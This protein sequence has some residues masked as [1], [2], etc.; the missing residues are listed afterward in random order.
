MLNLHFI[1]TSSLK[2]SHIYYNM[3]MR[4]SSAIMISWKYMFRWI[5]STSWVDCKIGKEMRPSGYAESPLA[6]VTISHFEHFELS[7]FQSRLQCLHAH[8]C[9]NFSQS[10][11]LSGYTCIFMKTRADFIFDTRIRHEVKTLPSQKQRK[12]QY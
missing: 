3:I 10:L 8:S 6:K 1:I 7:E 12:K 9:T 4:P 11:I 2:D 5:T